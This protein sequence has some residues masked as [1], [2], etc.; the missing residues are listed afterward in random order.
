MAAAASQAIAVCGVV[1]SDRGAVGGRTL[2]RNG[3]LRHS[4]LDT[5]R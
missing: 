4:E 1:G 3:L 5:I 2:T